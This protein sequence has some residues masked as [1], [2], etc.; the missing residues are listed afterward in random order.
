[1]TV[2]PVGYLDELRRIVPTEQIEPRTKGD[3]GS[4]GSWAVEP[5]SQEELVDVLRWAND[6]RAAV[7]TR[8]PRPDDAERYDRARIYLR[9]RRMQRIKDFDIVSCTMRVQAGIT[10]KKL[11]ETLSERGFTT[12]FPSRPYRRES[13]GALLAGALDSHWG[14]HYG[15]MEEHVVSLGV[16]LPDGTPARTR[17]A[18]RKADG[19][20][21]D[22]LFLGSRG[23]FGIIYEATI[24]VY[25]VAHRAVLSYGAKDLLSALDAA[26]I[27]FESGLQLRALEIMTPAADRSW[28]RKRVGLS[29]ELP[30]LVLV[31]PWGPEAGRKI[32][33]VADFFGNLLERLEPPAGWAVHEGLLPPP[34]EWT[35]PTTSASWTELTKLAA[36]LGRNVPAGLWIVR[37]S[38]HGAWL[39][40]AS[41]SKKAGAKRVRS[42]I[43][44][45]LAPSPG[46]WESIQKTLKQRLDPHGILNPDN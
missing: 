43:E 25:P 11:H 24:R 36:D 34:R 40:L 42:L 45:N 20:D 9:G 13:L 19:P 26:R 5:A 46:P 35:A 8:L 7:F 4:E 27:G 17:R 10:I 2:R 28:G 6:R 22:R 41:D 14:P 18:P 38:R 23:K 37:M 30:V 12:G 44:Q 29:N 1:M 31:E 32:S 3:A 16:V 15:S 33:V 21:F 39:S